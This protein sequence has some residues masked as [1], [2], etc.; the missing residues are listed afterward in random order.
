[1]VAAEGDDRVSVTRELLAA[2]AK[3]ND[4]DK[5]GATA[6]I[7]AAANGDSETVA[8]LLEKGA[9]PRARTVT[10][11]TPLSMAERYHRVQVIELLRRAGV[12]P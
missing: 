3:V 1:M 6:L 8:L 12:T 4:H 10:G 7:Q 5:A 2:G 11:E 9:D